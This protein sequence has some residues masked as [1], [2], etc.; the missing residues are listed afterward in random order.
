MKTFVT[1]SMVLLAVSLV[2][3]SMAS[4]ANTLGIRDYTVIIN[5]TCHRDIRVAVHYRHPQRGWVTQGW[6]EVAANSELPTAIQATDNRFYIH[7]DTQGALQ[8]PPARS[9]KQYDHY[10]VMPKDFLL[11][12]AAAELAPGGTPFSLKQVQSGSAGLKAR[13]DC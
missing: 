6:W 13:F 10:T 8:W 4:Q 2:P 1:A 5:N 11:E 9:R 3:A 12:G 7:G